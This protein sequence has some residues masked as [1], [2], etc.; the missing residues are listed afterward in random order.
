MNACGLRDGLSGYM[1]ASS[2]HNPVVKCLD[3]A[4]SVGVKFYFSYE[5]LKCKE[6]KILK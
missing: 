5:G 6:N 3:I 2:W 1:L 4:A